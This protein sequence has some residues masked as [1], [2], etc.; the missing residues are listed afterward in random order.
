MSV[1]RRFLGISAV[2]LLLLPNVG[3]AKEL[4][5]ECRP[6]KNISE[7]VSLD[8]VELIN[9]ALGPKKTVGC[10]G[11]G[12][13]NNV[14]QS[15]YLPR[16]PDFKVKKP[17]CDHPLLDE[18]NALFCTFAFKIAEKNGI[19]FTSIAQ[20]VDTCPPGFTIPEKNIIRKNS[21][22]FK[23][24]IQRFY[25]LT[26]NLALRNHCCGTNQEC[27]EKWSQLKLQIILGLPQNEFSASTRYLHVQMSPGRIANCE[28]KDCI[29]AAFYHELGHACHNA[30]NSHIAPRKASETFHDLKAFMGEVGTKCV[31]ER[32]NKYLNEPHPGENKITDFDEA[33]EEA[34]A[35]AVF[36]GEWGTSAILINCSSMQD[37]KH[38]APRSYIPCFTHIAKFRN[39]FC[40]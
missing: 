23:F 5:I 1:K 17:Y 18:R 16:L 34:Y 40:E 6:T 21:E 39:R 7:A 25:E 35:D 3:V 28:T 2:L 37:Y 8:G 29:D 22:K 19:D 24:A 12:K 27:I 9:L 30:E 13:S 11:S 20:S 10:C 36:A 38:A 32:L 26:A 33:A 31:Q 4:P 14:S 15:T